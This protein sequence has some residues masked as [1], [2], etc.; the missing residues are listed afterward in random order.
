MSS[1]SPLSDPFAGSIELVL[2]ELSR[3][4]RAVRPAELA[5]AAEAISDARR[6]FVFG[7]GRS[8]IALRAVAMR[9]MHLG[10][11]VH[12][13]GETTSPAIAAG[14]VLVLASGSGTTESIVRAA[15]KAAQL[16]AD[17]VIF[18]TAPDSPAAR[19]ARAVVVIPAAVKTAHG[20]DASQQYAGSLFEQAVLLLGDA[21]FHA[22]WQG[23]GVAAED[24]WPR[25]ANLE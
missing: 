14:D 5:S 10:L 25:H 19:G 23:S 21:L 18:T 17:T 15:E 6:V 1:S 7:Q 4:V 9:L 2:G 11:Q 24:L 8:G 3:S 16:G 12:V 22:L 13:V 20:S